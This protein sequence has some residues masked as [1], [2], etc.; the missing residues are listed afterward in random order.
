VKAFALM[1]VWGT[2]A[3]LVWMHPEVETNWFF[4]LSLFFAGLALLLDYRGT[5][6]HGVELSTICNE[7][8]DERA[9]ELSN[10]PGGSK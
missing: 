9:D 8:D 7:C 6:R 2:A 5:C 1:V 3:G 4:G 10:P